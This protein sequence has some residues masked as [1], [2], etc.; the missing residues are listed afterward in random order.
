MCAEDEQ[1]TLGLHNPV[2]IKKQDSTENVAIGH[3]SFS[4]K[5]EGIPEKLK[6]LLE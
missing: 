2:R 1:V 6:L 3:T 5:G 4:T